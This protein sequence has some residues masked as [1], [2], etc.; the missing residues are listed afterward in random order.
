VDA[1]AD[2]MQN[3]ITQKIWNMSRQAVEAYIRGMWPKGKLLREED[4]EYWR[5]ILDLFE[6]GVDAD[7]AGKWD[8]IDNPVE[9]LKWDNPDM[10]RGENDDDEY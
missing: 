4:P 1:R 9:I 2:K 3:W 10:Y 5:E 7:D 6:N 8:A